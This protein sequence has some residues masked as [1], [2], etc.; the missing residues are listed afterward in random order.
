M[1]CRP[2]RGCFAIMCTDGV[3]WAC[4]SVEFYAGRNSPV[5]LALPLLLMLPALAGC[6][7]EMSP[8][9][10]VAR[11]AMCELEI[12]HEYRN[13]LSSNPLIRG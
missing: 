4:V 12:P 8:F 9:C 11:E 1:F 13:I 10:K 3:A 6:R 2:P 7:Y 5:D